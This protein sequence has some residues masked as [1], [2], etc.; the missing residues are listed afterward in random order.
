MSRSKRYQEALKLSDKN[1]LYPIGDAIALAKKTAKTKFDGSM[2]AHFRLGIDA[3]KGEQQV[4]G[5]VSLPHGTGQT[6]KIIAFV[7]AAKAEEAKNSGADIVGTEETI[8]KIK[9][10]GKIDFDV[11]VATPEMM[12]KLAPIARILGPKGLMPSP[13]NK[14]ITTNLTK[15]ISALKTGQINFKNDDTGNVHQIFGKVSFEEKKLR[16]NFNA[17]MEAIKKVKPSSAKGVYL[18]N[19]SINATM[20]PGIKVQ[21]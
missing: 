14:T 11:A 3:S 7:S 5:T 17:L 19:I 12:A 9:A 15:T 8:N 4:R 21:I 16:E 18:K 6:K 2:E 20:G 10:S 13:K 1:K